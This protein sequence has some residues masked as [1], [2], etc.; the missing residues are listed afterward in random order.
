MPLRLCQKK[1]EWNHSRQQ[2]FEQCLNRLHNLSSCAHWYVP[3]MT[4]TAAHNQLII[5][6]KAYLPR[7][8]N[9]YKPLS[10]TLISSLLF[11]LVVLRTTKINICRRNV[12]MLA[13][14]CDWLQSFSI[15]CT[16]WRASYVSLWHVRILACL[17]KLLSLEVKFILAIEEDF[18]WEGAPMNFAQHV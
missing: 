17:K 9:S 8:V 12:R 10:N 14:S 3:G 16:T 13:S 18:Y 11:C 6:D 4:S 1:A 2:P 15:S 7:P 5:C